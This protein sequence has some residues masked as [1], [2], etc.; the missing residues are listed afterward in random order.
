M[1]ISVLDGSA[2]L[3]ADLEMKVKRRLKTLIRNEQQ[4]T[5]YFGSNS[6]FTFC[7]EWVVRE[8]QT[9][10]PKKEIERVG[11]AGG[12][13]WPVPQARYTRRV[14]FEG[15]EVWKWMVEQAD[16]VI[17]HTDLLMCSSRD[18]VRAYQYA[19][20][21]KG[22]RCI[23]LCSG[24]ELRRVREEI[25]SLVRW[26]R[27][28]LL[29]KMA[30]ERKAAVAER[31]GVSKTTVRFYEV[32]AQHHLAERLKVQNTP[33]RR[34]AIFGFAALSMSQETKAILVETIRYLITCC[35]VTSFVVS[36]RA[37]YV[38]TALL[39]QLTYSYTRPIRVERVE[40]KGEKIG[41]VWQ[42]R[43]ETY[44]YHGTAESFTAQVLEEKHA[45]TDISDIILCDTN[46]NYRSGLSY[47]RR[48]RVPVINVS[49]ELQGT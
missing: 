49:V 46:C 24:W 40:K 29:G 1:V 6:D 36:G 27:E 8:L 30:G 28:A 13:D 14:I 5:F 2:V 11:V 19:C 4:V 16:Y 35:G 18:R 37:P 47:A 34:C 9:A 23:N 7:C 20:A 42:N 39:R 21:Q 43:N 41:K 48:K 44:V 15:K 32:S 12:D 3:E 17:C 31:L 25:G 10:Y 38:L 45:M 33:S 26:E 22:E